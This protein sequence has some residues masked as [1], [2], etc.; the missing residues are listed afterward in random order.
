[1][2][3]VKDTEA[4]GSTALGILIAAVV[5]MQRQWE[6]VRVMFVALA[7]ATIALQVGGNGYPHFVH[8][9]TL[10]CVCIF[11]CLF[12]WQDSRTRK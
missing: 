4:I 11:V 10:C 6:C 1:M 3:T 2:A 7:V 8:V 12:Y 5:S 9:A